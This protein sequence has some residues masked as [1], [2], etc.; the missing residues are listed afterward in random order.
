MLTK[1]ALLLPV[2]AVILISGCVAVSPEQIAMVSPTVQQFL[3]DY[4]NAELTFTRITAA[5]AVN[6]LDQIRED[7]DNPYIE[8]KDFYRV[9]VEDPDSG[10]FVRA[11]IDVAAQQIECAYKAGI[12]GEPVEPVPPEQV[13]VPPEV[14]HWKRESARDPAAGIRAC[15]AARR[16]RQRRP[17]PCLSAWRR[18]N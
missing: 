4:P 8:A 18:R 6:Y 7:C 12:P 14:P 1:L 16:W 3:D 9:V 15:C 17:S 11:W 13:P 2:L 5:Q 10:L